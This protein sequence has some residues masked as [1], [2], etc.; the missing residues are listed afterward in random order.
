MRFEVADNGCVGDLLVSVRQYVF[1]V[2]DMEVVGPINSFA[3]ALGNY[4]NALEQ[5]VHLVGVRSVPD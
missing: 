5:A 4:T 3:N 1:V 2:D